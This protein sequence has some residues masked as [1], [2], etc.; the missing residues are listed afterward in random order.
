MTY[1]YHAER[2]ALETYLASLQVGDKVTVSTG[3]T[4]YTQVIERL[5]KTQLI[6]QGT[7]FSQ[8]RFRRSDGVDAEGG[9]PNWRRDCIITPAAA[10]ARLAQ[11]ALET[12]Q[13]RLRAIMDGLGL[14]PEQRN[15][16]GL[17]EALDKARELAE[18]LL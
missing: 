9:R 11:R 15:K 16:A 17:L 2:A 4:T 3:Q 13:R 12:R 18:E 14:A 7:Q 6:M 1:D 5:T 8:R 10:Q